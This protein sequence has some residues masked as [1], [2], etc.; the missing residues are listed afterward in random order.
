MRC[1]KLVL[2]K[3]FSRTRKPAFQKCRYC[4]SKTLPV[5]QNEAEAAYMELVRLYSQSTDLTHQNRFE[6]ATKTLADALADWKAKGFDESP[7]ALLQPL[8]AL[9]DLYR[10][11]ALDAEGHQVYDEVDKTAS[12][13]LMQ[14]EYSLTV[15]P[16][17]KIAEYEN[18][19]K[20]LRVLKATGLVESGKLALDSAQYDI[21]QDKLKTAIDLLKLADF[22]NSS[23]LM[24]AYA[25]LG[26]LYDLVGNYDD[27]EWFHIELMKYH[28]S[29]EVWNHPQFATTLNANQI[30]KYKDHTNLQLLKPEADE[31][32][33]NLSTNNN[34]NYLPSSTD[35]E[36]TTT[37][38]PSE[39]EL[40]PVENTDGN[41]SANPELKRE[42]DPVKIKENLRLERTTAIEM[43]KVMRKNKGLTENEI[44]PTLVPV[45]VFLS[46][47]LRQEEN[48]EDASSILTSLQEYFLESKTDKSSMVAVVLCHIAILSGEQG[49]FQSAERYF[50]EALEIRTRLLGPAHVHAALTS[51]D[52]ALVYWKQ[53]QVENAIFLIRNALTVFEGALSESHPYTQILKKTYED[54]VSMCEK[55]M[56]ENDAAQ[57]KLT[58]RE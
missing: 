25:Y 49:D 58:A 57:S 4:E 14:V 34:T 50:K 21:A 42:T 5:P 31:H 13:L 36:A 11:Q 44:H 30:V 2:R 53:G 37:N 46:N 6:E 12:D 54:F 18:Y 23:E 24:H 43:L 52:L 39:T 38:P 8:M 47:I 51:V 32:A 3:D 9:A 55:Y 7:L 1:S 26:L 41:E 56:Q 48:Y 17:E 27:A 28:P 45:M 22:S 33:P 29:I 35:A 40:K 10:T 15:E 16:P 20:C 19:R